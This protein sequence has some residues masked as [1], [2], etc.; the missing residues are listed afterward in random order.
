MYLD[1]GTVQPQHRPGCRRQ[2]QLGQLG[3]D[4]DHQAPL[5]PARPAHI[6]GVPGAKA[7]R[8]SPPFT[9]LLR[10]IKDSVENRQVGQLGLA[11]RYRKQGS[12]LLILLLGD[13]HTLYTSLT[14]ICL[15]STTRYN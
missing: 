8:Q 5:V 9:A 1:A 10:Q 2:S 7:R 11:P 3:K 6:D 13:F 14:R 4:P 15:Y 12:D